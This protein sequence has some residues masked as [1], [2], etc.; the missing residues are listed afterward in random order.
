MNSNKFSWFLNKFFFV[1]PVALSL[2]FII[3]SY[4]L[5]RYNKSVSTI[6]ILLSV[7]LTFL[8]LKL[9]YFLFIKLLK[10]KFKAAILASVFQFFCLFYWYIFNL[11][12]S[13]NLT[14]I[15]VKFAFFGHQSIALSVTYLL[16]SLLLIFYLKRS[17]TDLLKF[18]WFL[19]VLSIIFLFIILIQNIK[20]NNTNIT[21][22][23]RDKITEGKVGRNTP[24][25]YYIILDSYTG[26]NSL[27]KYWNFDNSEFINY[28]KSKGFYVANSNSNYNYTP[29]SLSSSLNMSY[30]DL[31]NNREKSKKNF[32]DLLNLIN[33]CRAVKF[34]KNNGYRF[35]NYS[36]FD[37][38]NQSKSYRDHFL[39]QD[40]FFSRSIFTMLFSGITDIR[41][42]D[43]LKSLPKDNLTVL[44]KVKN[45]TL[46]SNKRYFVYAHLLLPHFP[47]FFDHNG[48]LTPF[49]DA[50]ST[51]DQQRYLEQLRFTNKLITD[52][53]ETIL[54]NSKSK[55]IIIIQGDH[56]FR[57]LQNKDQLAESFSILNAYLFPDN[58]YSSLY[59]SISP[60]NTFRVMLNKYFG[61]KLNLLNDHSTD[62]F[63]N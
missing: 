40:R 57:F 21:L 51:G 26:N 49:I 53:I 28:L 61:T 55:P 23:N 35:I 12:N 15:I 46:D 34:I 59:D 9:N 45:L 50:Y 63:S 4:E 41:D 38:S 6:E 25:I 18:T 32:N 52:C 8:F 43:E 1:H 13:V 39:F 24:N 27:K 37:V 22:K 7:A 29:Y 16:F 36:F 42:Q 47:Y 17:N 19:N 2:I 31:D 48:K 14:Q 3:N 30:L 60:V 56:G 62:V 54:R 10:N 5:V 33:N 11:S 20:A 44:N 58:D